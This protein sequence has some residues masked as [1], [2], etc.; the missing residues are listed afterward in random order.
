MTH[1][2]PPPAP[3]PCARPL[4]PALAPALLLC[5]CSFPRCPA[6]HHLYRQFFSNRHKWYG[7]LDVCPSGVSVVQMVGGSNP[8]FGKFKFFFLNW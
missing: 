5:L 8:T 7:V 6:L 1:L 3:A 2:R 4:R